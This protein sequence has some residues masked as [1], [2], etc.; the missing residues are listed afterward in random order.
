LENRE[1]RNFLLEFQ[2]SKSI[3]TT[4][5][6]TLQYSVSV[7]NRGG[8]GRVYSDRYMDTAPVLTDPRLLD[9]DTSQCPPT[10]VE[11][12]GKHR[13]FTL[14]HFTIDVCALCKWL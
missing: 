9:Y 7:F 13:W 8:N 12:A 3:D 2:T 5:N 11:L 14:P 1:L 4:S 10:D 6:L